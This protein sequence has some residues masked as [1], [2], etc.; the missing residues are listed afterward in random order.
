MFNN[1]N[2]KNNLTHTSAVDRIQR[3]CNRW[4]ANALLGIFFAFTIIAW[5]YAAWVGMLKAI[6]F[7]T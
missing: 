6:D 3:F 5:T 2:I 1:S 4:L 7:L